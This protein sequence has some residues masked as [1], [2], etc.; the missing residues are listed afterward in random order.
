MVIARPTNAE[1]KG[2][3]DQT[4]QAVGLEDEAERVRDRYQDVLARVPD[5]ASELVVT[6]LR[7]AGPGQFRL[8]ALGGF[9]GSVAEEAGY[10]VDVGDASAEEAREGQIVYSNERLDVVSGDLLVTTSQEAGGPS[11][12]DELQESPLWDNIPAV[13]NDQILQ[14]PQPIYNGGTYVAAELLLEALLQEM[15]AEQ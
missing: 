8:D 12:I 7:G 14:L 4:V 13:E 15:G 2:A 5:S 11:N 3:F 9:G 1:W 10:L 6:F